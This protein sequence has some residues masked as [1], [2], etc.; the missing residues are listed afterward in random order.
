MGGHLSAAGGPS[1]G[2]VLDGRRYSRSG[3]VYRAAGKGVVLVLV[4]SRL[5]VLLGADGFSLLPDGV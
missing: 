3:G 2:G 1:H 5:L 4:G